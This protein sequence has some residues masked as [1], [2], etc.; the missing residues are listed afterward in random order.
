MPFEYD[1]IIG[2]V[3]AEGAFTHHNA[4][5]AKRPFPPIAVFIPVFPVFCFMLLMI[6]PRTEYGGVIETSRHPYFAA[7]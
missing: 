2:G 5:K 3:D 4:C 1:Q 6:R 7:E